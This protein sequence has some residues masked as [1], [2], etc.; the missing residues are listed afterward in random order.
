MSEKNSVEVFLGTFS[1]V[2]AYGI[3][4]LAEFLPNY[5]QVCY[6]LSGADVITY[7]QM[8]TRFAIEQYWI[9]PGLM[10]IIAAASIK[11]VKSCR[12]PLLNVTL[13]S[14]CA[15]LAVAW[16]AMFLF[17]YEGFSDTF[18]I[19]RGPTFCFLNFIK[20]GGGIFPITLIFLIGTLVLFGKP[21][22]PPNRTN[23]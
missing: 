18:S 2:L 21:F 20:F 13:A 7:L 9:F 6:R 15:Q 14:I 4:R 22:W 8:P 16:L 10:V 5:F 1:V 3:T 12:F 19:H 17:C 23:R 11:C